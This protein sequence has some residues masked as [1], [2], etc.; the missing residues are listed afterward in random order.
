MG[1]QLRFKTFN[2]LCR[3]K[4]TNKQTNPVKIKNVNYKSDEIQKQ[5][6]SDSNPAGDWMDSLRVD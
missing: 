3:Q 2:S 4:Q 5:F 1:L 6:C